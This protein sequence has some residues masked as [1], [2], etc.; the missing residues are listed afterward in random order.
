M[1]TQWAEMEENTAVCSQNPTVLGGGWA[2]VI[3][4]WLWDVTGGVLCLE[5]L[6]AVCPWLYP[7]SLL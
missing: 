4:V 6:R 3:G 7:S 1:V 2:P 5:E